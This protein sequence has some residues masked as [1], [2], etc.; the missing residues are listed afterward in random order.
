[1]SLVQLGGFPWSCYYSSSCQSPNDCLAFGC[2]ADH[3]V[4]PRSTRT[5]A[6]VAFATDQSGRRYPRSDYIAPDTDAA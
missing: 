2:L 6:E 4:P 1:M 5:D 3:G